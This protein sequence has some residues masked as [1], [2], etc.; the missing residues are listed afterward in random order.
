MDCTKIGRVVALITLYFTATY[1][2][3]AAPA[4]WTKREVLAGGP[5][6]DYGLLNQGQ[7]KNLVVKA[8]AEFEERLPGGVGPNVKGLIEAWRQPPAVGILRNDYGAVNQGQLKAVAKLFYSRLLEEGYAGVPLVAGHSL[9]WSE[10]T[11][12]D[13][14]YATANIGQA[15]NLFSFDLTADLNLNGLPDWWEHAHFPAT[16]GDGTTDTDGDGVSDVLEVLNQTDPLDFYNGSPPVITVISGAGQQGSPGQYLPQPVVMRI[17]KNGT[18][19][20]NAPV[21]IDIAEGTGG[22][23][24]VAGAAATSPILMLRTD[25][26]GEVRVFWRLSP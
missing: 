10:T 15:K 18:K 3:A 14:S 21:V 8:A 23:S 20:V 7:L 25:A 26:Q 11:E 2:C 19:L 1:V 17:T 22:I 4:W 13:A 9:P 6:N 24:A 12:D 5:A 16:A